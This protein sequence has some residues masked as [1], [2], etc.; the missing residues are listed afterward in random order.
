MPPSSHWTLRVQLGF[1]FCFWV[2]LS[3][4]CAALAV[5][6]PAEASSRRLGPARPAR[7]SRDASPFFL[8]PG[9]LGLLV[10]PCVLTG[11]T[12]SLLGFDW[13]ISI[14]AVPPSMPDMGAGS[15]WL[16]TEPASQ[17]GRIGS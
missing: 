14:P 16:G 12:G 5:M 13:V 10:G 9:L 3:G 15:L 4:F 11:L 17:L 2:G 1:P 7:L 8:N 6:G